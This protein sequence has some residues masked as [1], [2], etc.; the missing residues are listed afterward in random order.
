MAHRKRTFLLGAGFSKAVAGGPTM[1]ELWPWMVNRYEIE[2]KRRTSVD[3]LRIDWFENLDSNLNKL[4]SISSTKYGHYKDIQVKLRD[5]L[6]YVFTLI[7]L[8]LAAPELYKENSTFAYPA[9][10]IPFSK[11][12]L[13]GMKKNLQTYLYLIL[14]DLK[15]R[16][17]ANQFASVIRMDD[18][19][20]TFNYDLVLEKLLWSAHSWSPL[21]GYIGL[22]EFKK[23]K[24]KN[25]L[26]EA[27]LF[28]QVK[29]HKMHGSLNWEE[30]GITERV[31]RGESL[32]IE[33][34]DI[35]HKSFYLD[36]IGEILNRRA[37]TIDQ[38]KEDQVFVGRHEPGWILP[39]FIKPFD[40]IEFFQIWQSAIKVVS[41]SEELVIIGYSFRPEDSNAFLLISNLP[42]KCKVTLVDPQYDEIKERLGSKG[43]KIHKTFKSLEKYLEDQ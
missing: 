38:G 12:E 7:D 41:M 17:L 19:I 37:D 3:N 15:A 11:D 21:N 27:D 20:I 39:S 28:S 13:V 33:M 32:M 24:D 2:K 40:R 36:D 30:P 18:D 42:S 29:I 8:S 23:D 35:E 43:F 4:E 31:V 1:Q 22:T 26:A 6:E 10:P 14:V 34:D 25:K 16:K 9:I 5:N